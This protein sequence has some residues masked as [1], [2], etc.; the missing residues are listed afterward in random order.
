VDPVAKIRRSF[1]RDRDLPAPA[2]IAKGWRYVVSSALAPVHLRAC[3]T[4]GAGARAIGRPRVENRGRIEIGSGLTLNSTFAPAELLTAPGGEIRIGD[5][6]GINYGTVISARSRVVIGSGVSIGPYS[7]I[8]DADLVEDGG[9]AAGGPAQPIE[10]GDGVWLAGRVTLLPGARI[11]AGSVISAGSVVQGEIPPGVVAGGTPARVLRSVAAPADGPADRPADAPAAAPARLTTPAADAATPAV[12]AA[13]VPSFTGVVLA[14]FTIGDLAVRLRDPA[15][16]PVLH[17]RET[18]LGQ[19]AQ[20]LM[21]GA[22]EGAADYAVVWTR[23]EMVSTAFQRVLSHEPATADELLAEV[24]LFCDLVARGAAHYRFVFVPTWTAPY[25]QRGLGLADARPGGVSWALAL[26]N[27]R[28]ME[29]FEQ[30]P[31]TF[32]LDASRWLAAA[33]RGGVSAKAWYAGKIAFHGEALA[34]AARDVKAAVRGL[35]GGARKLVVVDLDDTLWGGIVGDAGWE[36]LQLG[37]HDA[38]GEALVDFQHALKRL[39]QRGIVLGIVSKNTESVALEAIRSHPAMVLREGDFV[40]WRIN[41]T[42]KARNVADLAAELNLGLQSVVFIDDNPVERARVREA[43]PEVLVPEW[44]EDKLLYPSALLALRCFD[45]PAISRE[46]AGRTALYAAE[47]ERD[48]LKRDVGSLDEWLHSL[49]IRVS[50]EALGPEN[51]TRVVQLLN[52]TN[53]MNLAT[54]RLTEAELVGWSQAPNRA[55]WA[56][57]VADRFGAAGLTGIVGLEA[58]GELCRVTDFVL[59]C[60]AMGRKVEETMAHLAV[61]WARARGAARVEALYGATAKNKPC[62]D[63]FKKSGFAASEGDTRFVWDASAAY[64][65]PDPISFTWGR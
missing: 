50:A 20:L 65:L 45:A 36:Q 64:A 8:A 21:Q 28:L 55:V 53:Q 12:A 52:K 57:T 62:H 35:T 7:I 30:A 22:P 23:P 49:D 51:V 25:Y 2:L 42:D 61:E 6:V 40:G 10:I 43:L 24:D 41:W 27:R 4:V 31:G 54:R 16:A 44:P 47:R 46:D 29:R 38:V 48:A 18:P 37:G 33:G 26:M 5:R 13:A 34:E 9:G 32:V 14:D 63:F 1:R 11:G 59:S 17:V 60:R 19:V 56:V 39:K 58:E 15:D 3:D